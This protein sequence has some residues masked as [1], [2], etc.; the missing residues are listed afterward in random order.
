MRNERH[1]PLAIASHH[2]AGT[3]S[4][5]AR[6]RSGCALALDVQLLIMTEIE[7]S[8]K[9][10]SVQVWKRYVRAYRDTC[11]SLVFMSKR[12]SV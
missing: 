11:V 1:L 12:L 2:A 8:P 4:K 6:L 10:S 7:G 3:T 9:K 5:Q